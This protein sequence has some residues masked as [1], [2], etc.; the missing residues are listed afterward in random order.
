MERETEEDGRVERRK[1][2][3]SLEVAVDGRAG[4][5]REGDGGYS[6]AR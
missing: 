3:G 4:G 1:R 6:S 2:G 5:E